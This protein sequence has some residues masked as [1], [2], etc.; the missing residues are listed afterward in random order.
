MDRARNLHRQAQDRRYH[1]AARPGFDRPIFR[2][3]AEIYLR[4]ERRGGA[5]RL[6]LSQASLSSAIP[7]APRERRRR[8]N[9]QAYSG[10]AFSGASPDG[11]ALDRG[12][13]NRLLSNP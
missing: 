11:S 8:L 9:R 7:P 6:L 3:E 10:S 4:I 13:V 2:R 12:T 1:R 5:A